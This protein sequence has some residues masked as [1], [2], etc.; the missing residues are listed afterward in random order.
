M[1]DL[2]TPIDPEEFE[3]IQ[4]EAGSAA[5]EIARARPGATV[6][7]AFSPRFVD[8]PQVEK[9]STQQTP[10][11]FLAGDDVEAKHVIAQLFDEGGP[12][13]RCWSLAACARAGGRRLSQCCN[14]LL[15]GSG[16]C[17]RPVTGL[18]LVMRS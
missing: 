9:T 5:Q 12:P 2:T 17:R 11:V 14:A 6:V 3:P 10:D 1:A 4:P 15:S 18:D 16:F 13:D 8:P 7:K